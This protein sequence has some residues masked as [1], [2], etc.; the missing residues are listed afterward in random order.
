MP[1]VL[2]IITLEGWVLITV[3]GIDE[4][5]SRKT[6]HRL[7]KSYRGAIIEES[8]EDRSILGELKI[9]ETEVEQVTDRHKTP[10]LTRWTKHMVEVPE[11]QAQ[12]VAQRLAKAIV[13]GHKGSWYADFKSEEFHYIIFRERVFK[14]D[15]RSKE[16]Y[17]E[18][19]RYGEALG[20][21][22]YQLDFSPQIQ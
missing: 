19:N 5:M 2:L 14:V 3:R 7:P 15:R 9:L 11:E 4:P 22:S 21:P 6:A 20:I 17:D 12:A 13:L 18:A 8:L 10:W 1:R 16:Q